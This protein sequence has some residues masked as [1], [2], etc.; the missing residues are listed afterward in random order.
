MV[1]KHRRCAP[2]RTSERKESWA[3]AGT[4]STRSGATSNCLG[5]ERLLDRMPG[6]KGPLPSRVPVAVEE[7]VV[8]G[9]VK[10]LSSEHPQ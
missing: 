3:T 4:S 10:Y 2:R 7:A 6:A 8:M 9:Q 5:A 1:S